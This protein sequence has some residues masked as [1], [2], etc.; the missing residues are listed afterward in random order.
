MQHKSNTIY[1]LGIRSILNF[2]DAGNICTA[3][4]IPLKKGLVYRS[5]HPDRISRKDIK[6]LHQLGIRTIID[7]RAP[8]EYSKRKKCIPGINL[9]SLPLDFEQVTRERLKPLILQGKQE[10]A[11]QK[12]IEELYGEILESSKP[13]LKIIAQIL[14]TDDFTPI[15]IHCRAGKDRTGIICALLQM[16]AGCS[17]K[18]IVDNFMMSNDYLLPYFRKRLIIRKFFSFGFFPASAILDA[19]TLRRENI[20]TVIDRVEKHYGGIAG[21][22]SV[23]GFD[24]SKYEALRSKLLD[25]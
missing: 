21:Y 15:L 8:G 19:I 20:E 17:W 11:V 5:A 4:G 12:V 2:R 7:L 22:L 25:K 14:F 9:L 10:E 23:S 13:V 18:E 6:K 3:D 24:M 16:I 1:D